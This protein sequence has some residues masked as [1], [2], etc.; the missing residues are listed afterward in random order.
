LIVAFQ[1]ILYFLTLGIF[2]PPFVSVNI[3]IYDAGKVLLIDR[4]DGLGMGLPGGFLTLKET[5][6]EAAI[7]EVKEETGLDIELAEILTVRS[8]KRQGG[9]IFTTSLFYKAEIVGDKTTR[10]SLEGKCRWIPLNR[11][12]QYKIAF[13][14]KDALK[15]LTEKLIHESNDFKENLRS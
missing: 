1:R 5:V 12:D 13:D 8:G 15:I 11:I 6:E 9:Q 7:R 3:I 2:P 10:D 14:H 4:T